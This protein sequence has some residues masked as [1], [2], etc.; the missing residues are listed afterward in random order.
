M[1][2]FKFIAALVLVPCLLA[3]T[4]CAAAPGEQP[5][6]SPDH[7]AAVSACDN[8]PGLNVPPGLTSEQLE[9][10]MWSYILELRVLLTACQPA[11]VKP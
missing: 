2:R 4:A 6:P 11:Q 1:P 3:L 10:S 5:G 7:L 9:D 8:D